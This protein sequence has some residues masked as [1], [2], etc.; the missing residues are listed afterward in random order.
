MTVATIS[1]RTQAD[2]LPIGTIIGWHSSTPPDGW[3]F[4][5]GAYVP[6]ADHRA[7]YQV[8]TNNGTTFPYGANVGSTFALP[9]L[10]N[11]F[12][13]VPTTTSPPAGANS[14][15]GATTTLAAHNHTYSLN[16]TVSASG[17]GGSHTHNSAT[18]GGPST[19]ISSGS[20]HNFSANIGATA[21]NVRSGANGNLNT[22]LSAHTHANNGNSRA[23]N[24]H[25]GH[26]H[27]NVGIN[28]GG[29]GGG[30][31]HSFN[32]S[33]PTNYNFSSA[34]IVA[35]TVLAFIVLSAPTKVVERQ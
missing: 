17:S 19:N 3:L 23:D 14:N 20:A 16:H 29:S 34:P 18:A 35:E 9:N 5:N 15:V 2:T 6:I 25:G 11:R 4:C 1:G 30:H 22:A 31:S 12:A 8:I 10:V 28:V 21:G 32:V 26:D 33:S 24:G 13:Q 27:P 7:L